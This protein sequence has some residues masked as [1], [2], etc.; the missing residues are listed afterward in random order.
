LV[1]HA[2]DITHLCFDATGTRLL[3]TSLDQ[4]ARLWE[5]ESGKHQEF[6]G[7]VGAVWSGAITPDGKLVLTAGEDRTVGIWE[8][9]SGKRLERFR[10]HTGPVYAIACGLP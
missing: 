8:A 2:Q 6:T 5:V 3:S 9:S 7:H 10:G 1:G 4:T